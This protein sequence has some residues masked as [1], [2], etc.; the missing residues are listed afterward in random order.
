[1][2]TTSDTHPL[3]P[4]GASSNIRTIVGN[5]VS[6][7]ASDV[8]N[9]IATFIL[10]ALIARYLG[11]YEFGQMALGLTL[12]RSFQLLAVAGLQALITREVAKEPLKTGQYLVNSSAVVIT[13]SLLS[14]IALML[15]T[16]IMAYVPSTTSVILLLSLGLFPYSLSVIC[17][18][19][20]R[21]R[22]K[23][24]YVAY[25]N[26]MVNVI[27]VA[28]AFLLLIQGYGLYHLI[29][30]LIF[31]HVVALGSKWWL[32]LKYITVTKPQLRVDFYFCTVLAKSS[33]TFLGINGLN[34]VMTSLTAVLLSKYVG[35]VGVGLYSAARQLIIPIE[36]VL[37]SIVTSVYPR[38]CR[39]F[40]PTFQRL[41][42]NTEHLLETLIAI[43]LPAVLGLFLL[44]D[45]ILVFLY[46]SSDFTEASAVLR[47]IVWTMIFR[48]FAKVLGLVLVAGLREKVTLRILLIDLLAV[49]IFDLILISQFGLIGAAASAVIVRVVDF[50]QHYVPVRRLFKSGIAFGRIFWKPVI[51]SLGM[52][53]YLASVPRVHLLLSIAIAGIIY[54]A[55][56]SV[57]VIRSVGGFYQFKA[58]YLYLRST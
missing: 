19:I 30:L 8:T 10:Y 41:K 56:L 46:G 28:V 39:A 5:T 4:R 49:L 42:R 12:F 32:L 24:Q 7:L 36:V 58:R 57:L 20:F 53:I 38:M 15:F 33:V 13:T 14:V 40:E 3:P 17:D 16:R 11:T 34:A 54:L 22:E 35:E 44:S 37:Q 1:M 21:A 43:V 48:V 26:L 52:I 6:V 18:A 25:S 29:I 45:E 9:R 55:I 27:K 47:I 51:P 23:M 2:K 50:L 31:L